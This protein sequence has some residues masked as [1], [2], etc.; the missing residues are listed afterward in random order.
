MVFE[1]RGGR[2]AGVCRIPAELSKVGG[3]CMALW[4][5]GIMLQVWSTGIVP[6]D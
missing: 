3:D 5:R 2:A 4:F 6:P 1:L